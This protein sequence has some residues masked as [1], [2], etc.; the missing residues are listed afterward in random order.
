[1]TRLGLIPFV[2]GTIV[3]VFTLLPSKPDGQRFDQ[4]APPA[5]GR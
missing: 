2:G 3:L 1:M 4:P 5:Y